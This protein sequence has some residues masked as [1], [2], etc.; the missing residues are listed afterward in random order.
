MT[1]KDAEAAIEPT[2]VV[3]SDSARR[4]RVIAYID[5][6]NLYQGMREGGLRHCYWLN[7]EA[8]ITRLLKPSQTLAR[9]RYFTASVVGNHDKGRRQATYLDALRLLPSVTIQFGV[10]Q[11]EP[12]RCGRCHVN[13][14]IPKEKQTDVAIA[15]AMM[16]D[17]HNRACETAML[18][19]GDSDLIPPV[20]A[21]RK[22]FTDMRVVVAFPPNRVTR[23][24]QQT[25]HAHIFINRATLEDCQFDDAVLKPNGHTLRRPGKWT[26]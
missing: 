11:S 7:L 13:W 2:A 9:I 12:I 17:A 4:E 24:L 22:N 21:I 23:Q 25:A 1:P 10:Y 26:E 3:P 20:Q 5:G 15:T 16:L 19:T 14:T 6:F 18:V 8:L